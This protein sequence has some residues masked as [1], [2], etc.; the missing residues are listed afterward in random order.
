[1]AIIE[2]NYTL[3]GNMQSVHVLSAVCV[4]CTLRK[5][6][7]LFMFAI[8]HNKKICFLMVCTTKDCVNFVFML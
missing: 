3:P 1:M 5:I 2:L 7:I 6:I 8:D 4:P